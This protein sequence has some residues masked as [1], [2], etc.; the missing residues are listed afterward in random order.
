MSQ[1][2]SVF[3]W[4]PDCLAF[5]SKIHWCTDEFMVDWVT[6][7]CWG[8]VAAKQASSHHPST[9]YCM[10]NLFFHRCGTVDYSFRELFFPHLQFAFSVHRTLVQ[11]SCDLLMSNFTNFKLC[12]NVLYKEKRTFAWLLCQ[13]RHTCSVSNKLYH[14]TCYVKPVNYKMLLLEFS[15]SMWALYGVTL[16][17]HP[18]LE[19]MATV[20]NVFHW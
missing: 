10:P 3:S 12:C 14:S 6:A 19:R 11:N 9:G 5:H 17:W 15:T 16:F 4:Q 8:A 7:R 2:C 20:L 1:L 18:L 13:T